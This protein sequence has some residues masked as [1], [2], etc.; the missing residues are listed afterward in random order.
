ME[1]RRVFSVQIKN[2]KKMSKQKATTTETQSVTIKQIKNTPFVIHKHEGKTYITCGRVL[3]EAEKGTDIEKLTKEL[4][5]SN[6]EYIG[7]FCQAI[8]AE[9]IKENNENLKK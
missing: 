7:I 8:C 4:Q 9:M 6:W 3:I 2:S 5:K 1:H